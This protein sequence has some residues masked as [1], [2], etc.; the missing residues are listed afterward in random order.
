MAGNEHKLKGSGIWGPEHR[1][2]MLLNLSSR[3]QQFVTQRDIPSTHELVLHWEQ[4]HLFCGF[5]G[6]SALL[7]WPMLCWGKRYGTVH[8]HMPWCAPRRDGSRGHGDI[9]WWLQ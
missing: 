2:L 6:I 7:W 1:D 9:N 3:M 8:E 4:E 5:V